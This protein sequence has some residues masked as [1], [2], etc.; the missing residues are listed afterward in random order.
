MDNVQM[1]LKRCL[2]D[3]LSSLIMSSSDIMKQRERKKEIN[4]CVCRESKSQN[5]AL[6]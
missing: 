3:V 4:S 6:R 2:K 1:A 5:E